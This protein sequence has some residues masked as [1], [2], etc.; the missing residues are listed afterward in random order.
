MFQNLIIPL[1]Q[2]FR[3][4]VDGGGRGN[5]FDIF[6]KWTSVSRFYLVEVALK[7]LSRFCPCRDLVLSCEK[8]VVLSRKRL[9]GELWEQNLAPPP[10]PR[11]HVLRFCT[12]VSRF[13]PCRDF[14]LSRFCPVEILS[15]EIL[16]LSRFCPCRDFVPVEILSLSRFC[17]VEILSCRGFV[18]RGS[19]LVPENA[20]II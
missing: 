13:C 15:V 7:K 8:I 11:A 9:V 6:I 3:K 16:S 14:V 1:R 20:N 4:T 18:C 19:V 5:S 2:K 12:Y 10:A 17:P